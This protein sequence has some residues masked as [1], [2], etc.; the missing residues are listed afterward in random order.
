MVLIFA[1]EEHYWL[2]VTSIPNIAAKLFGL[3]TL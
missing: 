2:F 3:D 1:L